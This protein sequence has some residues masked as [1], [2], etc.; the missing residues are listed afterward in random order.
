MR[1]RIQAVA[2]AALAGGMLTFALP[3]GASGDYGCDPRWSLEST[4][5]DCENGIVLAPG[6]DTRVNLS[7]LVRDRAGLASKPGTYPELDWDYGYGRT[8]FSWD[9][10]SNALYPQTQWPENDYYGSRCI[11][12][13][14]GDAA[15]SAAVASNSKVGAADRDA[16][17]AARSQLAPICGSFGGDYWLTDGQRTAAPTPAWPVT[18]TSRQGREF[19][20]YLVASAAFYGE[21]WAVARST[22]A[23]LAS[24]SDPWVKETARY[25]LGRVDLNAA[26]AGSFDEWGFFNGGDS[27]DKQAA[28]QGG[29]ALAA[30]LKAYPRGLYASSARGLERRAL[31][32][33]GDLAALADAYENLLDGVTPGSAAEVDLVQEID[34]KLF[35]AK[36]AG[37][38]IDTPLLLATYDLMRMRASVNE[39][40]GYG[41]KPIDEGEL[42]AQEPLFARHKDLYGFLRA[43][44]SFYVGGNAPDVLERIPDAS[45]GTSYSALDFSR[46][47]LRGQALAALKNPG[48]EAFWLRL[49]NGTTGLYQRPS[50]ELGLA[51]HWERAGKL[52]SIFADNSPIEDTMIRK[53]LLE[54]SASPEILRAQAGNL[55][56]PQAER[57]LALFT[58]LYKQL[59]YGRYSAFTSDLALL[60]A[61]AVSDTGL[62]QL[63]GNE[64]PPVG[65]FTS[66]RFS[67]GYACPSLRET[68]SSLARNARDV[69]ARL[70]LGEFYRL[71]GFD[72]FAQFS[73]RPDAGNLGG[74][75][76]LFT[77]KE[78]GRG[79]LYSSVI[80]DAAA[81][82]ADKAYALYRA[83]MCYAPSG[84]NSCGGD[85]VDLDQRKAWFNALK[86]QYADTKWA[87]ELKYYW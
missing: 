73:T 43:T 2:A 64:R 4:D 86:R 84:S 17:I 51:L 32:L 74:A 65:L 18:V 31:W 30:Y 55:A 6:N 81:P 67:D 26:Q 63:T 59:A 1:R 20:D 62:W 61:D 9:I 71:N 5:L 66:G 47:I 49:L 15:F 33:G 83:V 8:F 23:S 45:T 41:P 82:R 58:L 52:A 70:C 54:Q 53:I 27:V 34:N 11:S 76:S 16:L 60:P 39:G 40:Y 25:M 10:F 36:G 37:E 50:A 85:D 72:Y 28:A 57:E 35:M 87:R 7:L 3:A 75:P 24:A 38:A 22:F 79:D 44:Y 29:K 56:R 80:A 46:Q 48:E 78:S 68:A 14:G 42:A 77:G 19:L 69:K 12:L 13:Q 21:D